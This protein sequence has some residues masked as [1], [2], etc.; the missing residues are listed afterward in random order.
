MEQ[1]EQDLAEILEEVRRIE[2]QSRRLVTDVMAGGYVSVFRGAG[3]E[4]DSVR[5]AYH[6]VAP[7]DP[8]QVGFFNAYLLSGRVASARCRAQ[9][10]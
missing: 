4:F 5:I 9:R 6:G 10:S 8:L 1:G 7:Q 3:V 2:L